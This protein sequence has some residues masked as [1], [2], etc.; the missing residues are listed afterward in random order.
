MIVE[1]GGSQFYRQIGI[2]ERQH[3]RSGLLGILFPDKRNLGE[4]IAGAMRAADTLGMM[5]R[6][7]ISIAPEQNAIHKLM[8]LNAWHQLEEYSMLERSEFDRIA[9]NCDIVVT[10]VGEN[11]RQAVE[12][13]ILE[14]WAKSG[15]RFLQGNHRGLTEEQLKYTHPEFFHSTDKFWSTW[16]D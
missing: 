3:V 9:K 2:G 7:H 12:L 4:Q 1:H 10:G 16:N 14:I 13:G 15:G 11:V 6:A 8:H 5:L